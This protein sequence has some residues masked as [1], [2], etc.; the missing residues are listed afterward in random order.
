MNES[1]V[2]ARINKGKGRSASPQLNQLL[3]S[4]ASLEAAEQ[5]EPRALNRPASLEAALGVRGPAFAKSTLL[6]HTIPAVLLL[7]LAADL[8]V[9]GLRR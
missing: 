1:A 6:V 4:K 3:D 7:N 5:V 9:A 8:N 2:R